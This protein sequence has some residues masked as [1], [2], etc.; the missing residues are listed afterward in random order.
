[1]P[2]HHTWS[3]AHQWQSDCEAGNVAVGTAQ[4]RKTSQPFVS[5][6]R[7][8]LAGT[9]NISMWSRVD[10]HLAWVEEPAPDEHSAEHVIKV[11]NKP[12]AASR[13][14]L[15]GKTSAIVRK[16]RPGAFAGSPFKRAVRPSERRCEASL[17]VE[18]GATPAAALDPS[19]AFLRP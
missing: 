19:Q 8:A 15:R 14:W 5:A 13:S 9:G 12:E 7:S 3:A 2:A 6:E 11:A 17:E 16:V 18:I 10:R 1:V 4:V